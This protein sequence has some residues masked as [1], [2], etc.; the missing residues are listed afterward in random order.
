MFPVWYLILLVVWRGKKYW[1][2][3]NFSLLEILKKI[4][5]LLSINFRWNHFQYFAC[6]FLVSLDVV[7]LLFLYSLL[8][9]ITISDISFRVLLFLLSLSLLLLL[10]LLLLILLLFLFLLL[11]LLIY[12]FILGYY[13]WSVSISLP[14]VVIVT[15]FKSTS[16][17]IFLNFLFSTFILYFLCFF[18]C[19]YNMI[20]L[21]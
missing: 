9:A 1:H 5:I 7:Q 13:G 17:L 8:L 20:H 18:S 16:N 12:L 2:Y 19:C 11:Y 10:L 6:N 21:I 14:M 4:S 15:L 3:C